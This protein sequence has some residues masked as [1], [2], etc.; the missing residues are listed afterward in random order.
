MLRDCA[1]AELP[2]IAN[3]Y[4]DK[5]GRFVF[6]GRE[7]RFDPDTVAAGASPGAWNFTRWKV[8]DARAIELDPEYAQMRVLSYRRARSEIINSAISYPRGIAEVDIPGQVYEFA[9][10]I[11]A[12]GKHSGPTMTDLIISEGVTTGNTANQECFLYAKFF[13]SNQGGPDN[14]IKTLTLKS[15]D[16]DDARAAATWGVLCGADISDI[17]NVGVGYPGLLGLFEIS[18]IDYVD[19]YIEGV[20][21]RVRPL[22]TG[23]DLVELDLDV[24]P[25]FWSMDIH[26]VFDV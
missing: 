4:V 3:I 8:G 16:P 14:S 12:Y 18:G 11:T 22:N 10:S 17:V 2:G 7:S 23:Y 9:A 25:A 5:I 13:V 6:H 26:G 1:D 24:S 21:M 20:S 15:L 19:F